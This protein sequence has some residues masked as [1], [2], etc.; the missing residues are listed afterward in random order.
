MGKE[1][2]SCVRQWNRNDR[3]WIC[4]QLCCRLPR[5]TVASLPTSVCP[6]SLTCKWR[7]KW[8]LSLAFMSFLWHD[9][10]FSPCVL[11]SCSYSCVVLHPG[12]GKQRLCYVNEAVLLPVW[13]LACAVPTRVALPNAALCHADI[14]IIYFANP[15]LNLHL[16]VRGVL[17]NLDFMCVL[18]LS[19]TF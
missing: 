7:L 19:T 18:I 14:P 6:S 5:W 1:N 12:S 9:K 11:H 8:F 16:V 10:L 15:R 3:F 17:F 2:W 13:R 4:S